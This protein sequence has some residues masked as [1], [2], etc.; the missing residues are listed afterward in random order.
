MTRRTVFLLRTMQFI[1]AVFFILSAGCSRNDGQ[2]DSWPDHADPFGAHSGSFVSTPEDTS[3]YDPPWWD[4]IPDEDLCWNTDLEDLLHE[5]RTHTASPM[6]PGEYQPQFFMCLP[7]EELDCVL[8]P[9]RKSGYPF[10]TWEAALDDLPWR[11]VSEDQWREFVAAY[12]SANS[13]NDLDD[14]GWWNSAETVNAI[15]RML[16]AT[17]GSAIMMEEQSFVGESVVEPNKG[18]VWIEQFD[19]I[20]GEMA[21]YRL[22][23]I[24]EA[25][26]SSAIIL[27]RLP[28]TEACTMAV[29]TLYIS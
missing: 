5:I 18:S 28:N 2:P 8:N 25:E 29:W 17:I 19:H 14:S 16:P 23:R 9:S 7:P 10:G 27:F 12:S 22:I 1:G 4:L 15:F 11:P 6:P 3:C 13:S 26:L 24:F 21:D 20:S